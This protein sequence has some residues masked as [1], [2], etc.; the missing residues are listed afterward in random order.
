M[1]GTQTK[2]LI[3]LALA[4]AGG[5]P[6]TSHEIGQS[7]RCYPASVQG[8]LSGMTKFR[9]RHWIKE[10]ELRMHPERGGERS[11]T[12]TPAGLAELLTRWPA[13]A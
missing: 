12:I 8:A 7:I 4:T 6:L 11:W 13:R 5:R 9:D 3:A 2:T 1:G 10:S